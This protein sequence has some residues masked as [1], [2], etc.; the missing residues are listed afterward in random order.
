M[1]AVTRFGVAGL[2]NGGEVVLQRQNIHGAIKL[3]AGNVQSTSIVLEA[4]V[5]V[6]QLS[7]LTTASMRVLLDSYIAASPK[8]PAHRQ[9]HQGGPLHSRDR[10]ETGQED[11]RCG[12]FERT[13]VAASRPGLL[14]NSPIYVLLNSEIQ[15]STLYADRSM[16]C[17]GIWN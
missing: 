5:I 13:Q 8:F 6:I 16:L 4:P 1:A 11:L 15:V 2:L 7:S 17:L 10:P 3:V 14:L 9:E 12:L